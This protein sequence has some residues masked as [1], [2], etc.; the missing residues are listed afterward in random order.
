MS[1]ILKFNDDRQQIILASSSPRR[2]K[3]LEQIGL[4]FIIDAIPVD[5]SVLNETFPE[6]V[7]QALALRK[8][9]AVASKYK[10][11]LVIGA[12]TI[13]VFDGK[14]LGKPKD[15][16]EAFSMLSKLQGKKHEVYT[17]IALVNRSCGIIE[18]SSECTSV[19]FRSL[20]DDEIRGYIATK[21]PF[22]KAGS[23]A[24]QG[25]GATIVKRIEGDYF[26]VV[27]L[28]LCL[29]GIMLKEHGVAMF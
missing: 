8:A 17:G 22:G 28:P 15:E 29:L 10:E 3:L 11:G 25:L 5:E 12:D 7:V 20:S 13:V 19:E 14:I 27:G 24:I 6:K 16:D 26:N 23:Y 4:D 2:K 9:E 18:A 1:T 21:E